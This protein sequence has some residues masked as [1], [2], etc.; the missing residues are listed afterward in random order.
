M[1]ETRIRIKLWVFAQSILFSQTECVPTS[2]LAKPGSSEVRSFAWSNQNE[3]LNGQLL[4]WMVEHVFCNIQWN[5]NNP[6]CQKQIRTHN[7]CELQM[8]SITRLSIRSTLEMK[9]KFKFV[10][11]YLFPSH[12]INLTFAI[13]ISVDFSICV[14]VHFFWSLKWIH[15]AEALR[16]NSVVILFRCYAHNTQ[17]N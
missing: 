13:H 3:W 10:K 11:R 6:F 5:L 8:W 4:K 14:C 2:Y 1:C 9:T 15:A 17:Q 16:K 12:L 7:E